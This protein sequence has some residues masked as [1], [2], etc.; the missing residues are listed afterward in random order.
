MNVGDDDDYGG[1]YSR[2]V[3]GI[4][5]RK[6]LTTEESPPQ[7]AVNVQNNNMELIP[8]NGS[9]QAGAV[10]KV[11][12]TLVSTGTR[13]KPTT[14]ASLNTN[15]TDRVGGGDVAPRDVTYT[16]PSDSR[17][18]INSPKGSCD[19]ITNE[20][21]RTARVT[22]IDTQTPLTVATSSNDRIV[23]RGSPMSLRSKEEG[24]MAVTSHHVRTI[25]TDTHSTRATSITDKTN[26][27]SNLDKAKGI[28]VATKETTQKG[29]SGDK[30][31]IR[32]VILDPHAVLLDAAVEG[33]LEQV[34]RVIRDVS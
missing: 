32:H 14:L 25:P 3:P 15:R 13:P 30:K 5:V 16:T 4:P 11:K 18:N 23:D 26:T 24:N 2:K 6:T 27:E 8:N 10:S 7:K 17:T 12:I 22:A 20:R 9:S 29:A 1:K 19:S 21:I 34:K 28:S 31:R 33:E